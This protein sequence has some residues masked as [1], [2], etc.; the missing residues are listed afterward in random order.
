MN[1]GIHPN[2]IKQIKPGD[3]YCKNN[4]WVEMAICNPRSINKKK[5][6]LLHHCVTED[7]DF[8]C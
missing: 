7:L 5:G 3:I 8:V 6:A 1:K 4:N 2:N